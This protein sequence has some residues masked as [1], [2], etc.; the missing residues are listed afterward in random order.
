MALVA[1]QPKEGFAADFGVTV[2]QPKTL[3]RHPGLL[4]APG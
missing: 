2:R 1:L 4:I 3:G